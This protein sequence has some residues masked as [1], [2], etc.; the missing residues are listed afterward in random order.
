MTPIFDED[1]DKKIAERL[2]EL[3]KVVRDAIESAD[4][5]NLL[6]KMA[7]THKLHLDQ[8]ER[9]ENEVMLTLLGFS[10]INELQANIGREVGVDE[11]T[12]AALAGDISKEVFE[13]I[14][15]ELE[16]QLEHPEAKA[17]EVSGE[18]AARRQILSASEESVVPAAPPATPPATATP[19]PITATPAEPTPPKLDSA[20]AAPPVAPATPPAP[21]PTEK[22]ARPLPSSGAYKH[23][24]PSTTRT[25]VHD[26]PYREPPA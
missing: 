25:D 13:P 8:W 24:E 9:L 7:D 18:E 2:K 1:L 21:A 12:A 19:A 4:V 10:E 16:R 15:E 23:G 5:E 6:R 11:K 14:R 3:P 26:D 22:A 20:P 17:E